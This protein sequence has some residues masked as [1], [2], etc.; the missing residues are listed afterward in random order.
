MIFAVSSRNGCDELKNGFSDLVDSWDVDR[1]Y[2]I[3]TSN[4]SALA[5]DYYVSGW[6]GLWP[7]TVQGCYCT[8]SNTKRK[9]SKGLKS[10][11]CNNNETIVGCTDVPSS[12]RRDLN[13]WKN[14]QRLYVIRV[15]G[16]S[17]LDTYLKIDNQ[18]NCVSS[19]FTNCGDKTSKSRGACLPSKYGKCTLTDI[20]DTSKTGYNITSLSSFNLY[21]SNS[22]SF[23]PVTEAY[24]RHD[25]L[26]FIRSQMPLSPGRSKYKLLN[27]DYENCNEDKSAFSVGSMKESEFYDLNTFNVKLNFTVSDM[28]EYSALYRVLSCSS[29]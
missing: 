12:P 27:G 3:T 4:S 25:H 24:I 6:N 15:K 18:G 21:T 8:I 10:R 28:F 7:G 23:N 26:C 1:I 20:S 29:R 11:E 13:V 14:N 16:T 2:D 19:D 5:A 9:V 17:F 22:K